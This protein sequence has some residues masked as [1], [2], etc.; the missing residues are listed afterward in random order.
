MLDMDEYT[1]NYIANPKAMR[2][3]FDLAVVMEKVRESMRQQFPL[4]RDIFRRFDLDHDGVLT[5]AEFKKALQKF[6]FMLSDDEV[7]IVMKHFD[8]RQDGQVSYNE[9]CDA[10][11]DEDYTT[12][13]LKTKPHVNPQFDGNYAERAGGKSTDREETEKVRKAVREMGDVV[14]QRHGVIRKL[15]KEFETMTH[16][17]SVS[18]VQIKRALSAMGITI[19]LED[20][21]RVILYLDQNA[22]LASVEY[23][24]FF[25]ALMAS[26]HD[27]SATR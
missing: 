17:H 8:R 14:Y 11:L 6:G 18:N 7:T 16:E 26:F 12:E 10:L 25:K 4:V 13:M 1:M 3:T 23:V 24:K 21:D 2:R 19:K 27:I 15:Y 5:Q 9:F 22:N 20:I